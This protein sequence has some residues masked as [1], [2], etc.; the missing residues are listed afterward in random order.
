MDDEWGEMMSGVSKAMGQAA[1]GWAT[2]VSWFGGWA[3]SAPGGASPPR[4]GKG[5]K[6]KGGKPK[7]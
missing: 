4:S 2:T 1:G 5:G 6:G 3:T 7:P